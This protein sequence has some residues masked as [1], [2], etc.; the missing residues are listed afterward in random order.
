MTKQEFLETG[1]MHHYIDDPKAIADYCRKNY[2]QK[3]K[4]VIAYAD[5]FCR[6]E[7]LFNTENDLEQLDDPVCYGTKIQW[8]Y[9]PG[10][11]PEYVWQFNRHRYFITL[12]Q[13]YQLTGDEKYARCYA[14]MLA[15][16]MREN[17][18]DE[19]HKK[20][21]WR[22]LEAGFRGEYWT[23]A[24]FYFKDS[25]AVTDELT[26][27]FCECLHTHAGYIISMHS[28]YRLISNW[29]VIENHG[30]FEIALALP[31]SAATEA[32]IQTAL[33]HLE[34]LSRMAVMPDG[35][36]WEQSPMYHNEVLKGFLDVILLADR[37]DI[38][39]PD[40]IRDCA[41]RMARA[42]LVWQKPD[43]HEFMMGDS[44]D[45][46][47]SPVLCRA[48]CCFCDPVLKYGARE[49]PD[50]ETA[51]DI[52]MEGI[53]AYEAL[54]AV[55]PDFTSAELSDTGNYYLRSDWSRSANLLHL[56]CGTIGAGHG[57]SDQLH[58]DLVAHGEDVLM[59]GGRYT[60]V[61]G[62]KRCE[63]KDPTMHN[64][65]TVDGK[66]FTICKDSW[67]CSKLSAPVK[68]QFV[69]GENYEFVQAGHLGY[70][71]DGVFVNRKIVYIR[72]DVYIIMDECYCGGAHTYESY[73]HFNNQGGVIL[74]GRQVNYHGMD[75]E[76]E[77]H[78][79]SETVS[80]EKE[81]THFSRKYNHE[82]ENETVR[83]I[84][85]GQGFTSCM[86]VIQA[87]RRN[88]L[89]PMT[90]EKIPVKSALKQTVYPDAMAEA[91]KIKL[92]GTEYVV[93]FCHQEVNSPTDLVEADGC[94]GFG[95]VIVFDKAEA[96]EVG[97][98]LHW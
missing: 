23:K 67:E 56:H 38:R 98:T 10:G 47:I 20:T 11:D 3:V 32:Y 46:D 21:T 51:W 78:F 42:D 14:D 41:R 97:H 71:E 84:W 66:L 43:H 59:D 13:A 83:A 87:G 40:T 79:V 15:D 73:Y 1:Y 85:S 95:T 58:I 12:G 35:V 82:E 6:H 28:P 2:P 96:T 53:S 61:F 62:K 50:F 31:K 68:Q 8:D 74:K 88:G 4:E 75:A 30:L 26:E 29:G 77:F 65:I 93:I 48:A 57:H 91:V 39:I 80:L 92:A 60:Y 33:E 25:P 19:E 17:P 69:T 37:N 22:I 89:R 44:D 63:Y 9:N 16:W 45:F 54:K 90:C 72:P 81:R 49:K 52:G 27:R 76:A 34:K 64:T 70:I 7:F 5:R 18:L 24:F 55:L 86:T 36:E 94:L